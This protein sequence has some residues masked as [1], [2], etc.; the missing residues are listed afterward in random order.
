MTTD[1]ALSPTSTICVEKCSEP[2]PRQ[3]SPA[4]KYALLAVFCIAQ[5]I[6]VFN[7]SSV[8]SAIPTLVTAL[9]MTENESTWVVS[10]FQLTF[11]S[12][13]LV[14]CPFHTSVLIIW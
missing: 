8:I 11:A 3:L 7:N 4:R 10:A 9:D 1:L 12:F 14:V 2:K 6:D 5:L 13:L